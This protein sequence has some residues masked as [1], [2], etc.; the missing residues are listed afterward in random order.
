MMGITTDQALITKSGRF[1]AMAKISPTMADKIK[2]AGRYFASV[3]RN[4]D[5]TSGKCK[6]FISGVIILFYKFISFQ[7]F[8]WIFP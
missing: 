8:L 6:R 3:F 5:R 2:N 1:I 7:N 4:R